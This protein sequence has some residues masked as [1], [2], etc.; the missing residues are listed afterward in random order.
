MFARVLILIPGHLRPVVE[1]ESAKGSPAERDRTTQKLEGT[2]DN[3]LSRWFTT[4]LLVWNEVVDILETSER[5]DN[6]PGSE[7]RNEACELRK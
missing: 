6:F 5:G 3:P 7:F 1:R 2:D 4:C